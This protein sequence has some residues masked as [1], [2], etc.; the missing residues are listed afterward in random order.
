MAFDRLEDITGADEELAIEIANLFVDTTKTYVERLREAAQND[1]GDWSMAAHALKG[2]C[3]NFG[4]AA[5][6]KLAQTSEQEPPSGNRVAEIE[7]LLTET[8]RLLNSRYGAATAQ[9]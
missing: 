5:L 9:F 1:N 8:C 3:S 6:A 2:C 4:A 7:K